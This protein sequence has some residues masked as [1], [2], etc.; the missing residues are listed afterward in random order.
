MMTKIR[1]YSKQWTLFEKAW[2]LIF[3]L[4][5]IYLFF[6][7]NDTW[8]GLTASLSGMLCVVLTAKGKISSFYFGLINIF[9]Y[10]YVA[11]KSDYYGDVMLNLLYF[12]PM[13]F[14]GIYYWKRNLLQENES[15]LVRSLGWKKKIYWFIF[16][17][18]F[19]FAYGLFL[20]WLNGTLPFVDSVTTVFS[21]V[22]TIMLTKRLT[23]QWFYWIM[24]DVWSIVM[25]AY[26]FLRDGNDATVLVM[27]VAFL[28]N[29]VY[30]LYN[31]KKM[32]GD[33]HGRR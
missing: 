13:T 14:F 24:V 19:V 1:N 23:D 4:V 29:A 9:T 16:S 12:L 11:Y 32:E 22:A 31:W 33:Q 2:L 18:V 5:N 20:Q 7:W 21:I 30:G 28:V 25:W 26:I 6:A 27:W 3:T 15:V 8:V 10:S 17:L